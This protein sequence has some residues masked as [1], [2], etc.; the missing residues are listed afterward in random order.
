M[1]KTLSCTTLKKYMFD[2]DHF[3]RWLDSRNV[4]L[5]AVPRIRMKLVFSALSFLQTDTLFHTLQVRFPLMSSSFSIES[6]DEDIV[7]H[8]SEKVYV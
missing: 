3:C 7:M 4:V 8:H 2:Y 5:H 1:M 6:N